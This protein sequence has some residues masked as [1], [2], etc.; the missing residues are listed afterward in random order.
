MRTIFH[1]KLT[2]ALCF[3]ALSLSVP[4]APAV[5]PYD[6]KMR[7]ANEASRLKTRLSQAEYH[8]REFE[9]EVEQARGGQKMVWRLKKPAMDRVQELKIAYPNDPD[10]E[11]L[12]QRVRVALMKS[13]GDYTQIQPEWVAYKLNEENLRRVIAAESQ[14]KWDEFLAAHK[15]SLIEH[16][17]SAPDS[18]VVT[19]DEIKGSFVVL[20]DVQYPRHQFY[21]ATGEFV[22]C[23]KPSEGY[24]FVNIGTRRWVGSYE[25]VKRF[26]RSVDTTLAEV[27]KWKV[28]GQITDIT[29]EVP[30]AGEQSGAVQFGWIVTPVAL[31]VP[32]HVAAWYDEKTPSSSSYAGE[33][34]VEGIKNG[35]YTV[36][37]V[38]AD[39]SPER[40]ME[41]FMTAIKEKNFNLYRECIDSA[42]YETEVGE[43]LIR[44]HWDRH[45][46][47]FHSQ[48]VH[49][50]F[51]KAEISVIKGF[52][53]SEQNQEN[54]FLDDEQKKTLTKVMG[55]KIEQAVVE[56]VSYDENGRRIGAP[57]KHTLTRTNGGRWHVVNYDVRF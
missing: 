30:Q 34:Q 41:I 1:H 51:G 57:Q 50:S 19:L 53:E 13:K 38:P 47:R 54:F 55:Q 32:A 4:P 24:Y 9:K 7:E 15:D 21:G 6:L 45:Q 36:R 52:D 48:Y 27:E 37:E 18:T 23:G 42:R 22:A 8:V 12:Y 3:A 2:A 40:V 16:P 28:L 26:R 5:S 14:K 17:F 49:A 11:K 43:D 10:V 35:W 46:E 25:A 29:A 39:A 20:D 31:F 56:S 33:E 44:Y